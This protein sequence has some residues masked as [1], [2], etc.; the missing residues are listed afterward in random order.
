M[1][2]IMK[3][4]LGIIFTSILILANYSYAGVENTRQ[5]SCKDKSRAWCAQ[6]GHK[7]RVA[8]TIYCQ[9]HQD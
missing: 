8:P 7:C 4:F 9:N 5:K 6:P 3:G 2:R 1:E